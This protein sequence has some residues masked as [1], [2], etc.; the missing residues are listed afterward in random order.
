MAATVVSRWS[1]LLGLV[2]GAVT[3]SVGS[4]RSRAAR[5]R[6]DDRLI[7]EVPDLIEL[8]RLTNAAGLTVHLAVRAVAARTSGPLGAALS[9]V[10]AR[11]AVGERLADGLDRFAGLGEP[12]R[13]LG[14]A[15]AAA[16]RYGD[17]LAPVLERVSAEARSVRRRH[18]EEAARRLP[19]R[20]LLP[21]VLCVL[22]AFVLLAV[23][24]LLLAA[25]PRLPP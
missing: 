6:E 16:E 9:E 23:A 11:V 17:P 7:A 10:E 1:L 5:Q 4:A 8:F 21:L 18:A 20:L 24:P 12:V 19:V 14:A 25:V 15:L 13:P 3:W 22:P 2:V